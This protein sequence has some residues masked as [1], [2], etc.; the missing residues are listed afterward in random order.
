MELPNETCKGSTEKEVE[1]TIYWDKGWIEDIFEV[2]I[3]VCKPGF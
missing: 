3:D 2:I 1:E